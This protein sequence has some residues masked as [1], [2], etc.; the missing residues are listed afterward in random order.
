M[1]VALTF[2]GQLVKNWLKGN[3]VKDSLEVQFEL[4][5]I[6][7]FFHFYV[8]FYKIVCSLQKQELQMIFLSKCK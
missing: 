7:I 6:V 1:E 5:S 8:L 4:L 3:I 2:K